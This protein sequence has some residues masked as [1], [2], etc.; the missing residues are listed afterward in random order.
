LSYHH[1]SLHHKFLP[2]LTKRSA[3][4]VQS[5]YTFYLLRFHSQ[6]IEWQSNL[7]L[8]TTRLLEGIV[9]AQVDSVF[10]KRFSHPSEYAG[11]KEVFPQ[12]IFIQIPPRLRKKNESWNR[13]YYPHK[14]IHPSSNFLPRKLDKK[15]KKKTNFTQI[16]EKK[17][18]QNQLYP[19]V[20]PNCK[21]KWKLKSP[22]LSP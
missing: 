20:P 5:Q 15:Y 19:R 18:K 13:H 4:I 12:Q 1:L 11:S 2:F 14:L 6:T 22:L 10:R 8:Q 16:L 9:F 21:K 7:P 17:S 3:A